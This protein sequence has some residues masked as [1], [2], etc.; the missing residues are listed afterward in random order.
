MIHIYILKNPETNEIKYVGKTK[1][2]KRRLD[3]HIY[4]SSKKKTHLGNWISLLKKNNLNP[5][6]EVIEV[7]TNELWKDREIY[8]IEFYK[9]QGCNLCNHALGGE[10]R[11]GDKHSEETRQKMSESRKGYKHKPESILKMKENIKNRVITD[12]WRKN[13][14]KAANNKGS[15]NANSLITEKDAI[16]IKE[17]LK[18]ERPYIVAKKLNISYNIVLSIHI[19]R[20]WK[21]I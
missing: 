18:S 4:I 8:W 21:H 7:T 1:N 14:S 13:M 11:N 12:E 5:L 20:T 16:L 15:N 3:Q 6:M 19:K 9:K 2:P 17:M 10:G